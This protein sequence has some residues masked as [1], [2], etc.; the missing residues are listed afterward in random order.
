VTILLLGALAVWLAAFLGGVVGFAYGLVA[1]PLLLL[2]GV[3]LPDV[4]V[5]NLLVGLITRLVVVVRR[6]A[7]IDRT[8]VGL[9]IAGSLLGILLGV[10]V[11][12]LIDV[13][14]IQIGAG[15]LTLVAVAALMHR[16]RS[17]PVGPQQVNNAAVVVTAGA[18]GGF[19]GSTTSLNG[20]P[21]ALLLTGS[22]ATTRS[23]V[24]DLAAYFVAGNVLT[25]LILLV[26]GH[27]PPSAGIWPMLALWVPVSL[28][29]NFV[30]ITLG[31]RL[32]QLL[33]R[34]LTL[35]VISISGALST[36]QAFC[37]WPS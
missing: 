3:P 34:R 36:V 25:L 9:L 37:R 35:V 6:H 24:A 32:P 21:P 7:D 27:P 13:R 31:P 16:Q 8:R 11:R 30:G 17:S 18:L 28:V 22:R 19:L 23:L 33:F 12:D 14:T 15:V 26:R 20:V 29:A 1:L 10:V 5:I 4:V 2:L